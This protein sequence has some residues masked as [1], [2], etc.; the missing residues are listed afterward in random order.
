VPILIRAAL[1]LPTRIAASR[2][3]TQGRPW[4]TRF[5]KRY[6]RLAAALRARLTP[7]A[8][9]GLPL[10]LIILALA[11]LAALQIGL[12]DALR[13]A[14]ALVR[15]DA[16]VEAVM[17]AIRTP[18]L[19]AAALWITALGAGP[20]LTAVA[21]V[22][23]A[24]LW[25]ARRAVFVPALWVSFLG[26]QATTWIGKYAIGR[27]RPT[28]IEAVSASSPSYPS[29]HATGAMAVFGFL[30]YVL[31]RD[32][33]SPRRRFEII[34]WTVVLIGLIGFSRVFL[35]VHFLSDVLGGLLVGAFWLLVG[36]SL[37]EWR[38][39]GRDQA[40]GGSR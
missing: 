15:L 32:L 13:E 37:A 6:P 12:I 30:A 18:P 25:V 3:W 40:P 14:D 5:A 17:A 27:V 8:F 21:V 11:G 7:H 16:A 10:F 38:G 9:T 2:A 19:I 29:G 36:V 31:T 39:G 34:F 1:G 33:E 4:W 35:N 20:A 22:A 26:A 28:F 24:F 23:T